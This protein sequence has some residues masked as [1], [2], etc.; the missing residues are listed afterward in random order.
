MQAAMANASST[1]SSV[2]IIIVLAFVVGHVCVGTLVRKNGGSA[3]LTQL[4]S[5][6]ATLTA[7]IGGVML[8]VRD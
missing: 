8:Y 1:V 5:S 4:A 3:K 2:M 6:L 7:L